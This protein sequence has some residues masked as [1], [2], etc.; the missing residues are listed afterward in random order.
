[1]KERQNLT[2]KDKL[3]LQ[4]NSEEF[5]VWEMAQKINKSPDTIRHFLKK[6][7]LNYKRIWVKT[8][9]QLTTRESEIISLV[10]I[11]MTNQE[12]TKKLCITKNTLSTHLNH[13]YKKFELDG[14]TEHS[15][16]RLKAVLKYQK[17]VRNDI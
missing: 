3:F 6:N 12:I 15:L 10:A 9:N 1:M 4:Q 16:Q 11:G 17:E 2:E 5:T 7:N 14:I 8:S 13:I